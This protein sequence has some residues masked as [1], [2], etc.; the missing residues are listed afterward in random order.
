MKHCLVVDDSDVIRK[1]ARRIL[2]SRGLEVTEAENGQEAVERC[3]QRMPD[4]VLLDWQMPVMSGLEFLGALRL[5][6]RQPRPYIFY[7]TTE[8]DPVEISR[9]IAGGANDYIL[10]P[11]DRSSLEGKLSDAGLM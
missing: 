1:V 10:K 2:E 9:A 11:F 5:S 6:T 7:C 3:L 8:N 4:A